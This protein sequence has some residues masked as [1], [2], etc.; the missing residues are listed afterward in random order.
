MMT[1]RPWLAR[2][3]RRFVGT[4]VMLIGGQAFLHR[5]YHPP[6]Q[7]PPAGVDRVVVVDVFSRSRYEIRDPAAARRVAAFVRGSREH[8]GIRQPERVHHPIPMH[9]LTFYR[10]E[11]EQGAVVW[12]GRLITV[13]AGRREHVWYFLTAGEAAEFQRL[14]RR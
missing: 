10:G 4:A 9:T 6:P 3:L 11:R 7:M 2:P 12:S 5:L 1:M 14:M 13:P 8:E